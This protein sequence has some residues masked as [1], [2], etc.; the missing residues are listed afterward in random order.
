MDSII[1]SRIKELCAEND[2]TLNKLETEVGM[3]AYSISKGYGPF[4]HTIVPSTVAHPLQYVAFP[5]YTLYQH[6]TILHRS[7]SVAF[8]HQAATPDAHGQ[9]LHDALLFGHGK[10][11]LNPIPLTPLGSACYP[12][13]PY[14]L[15]HENLFCELSLCLPIQFAFLALTGW[16]TQD[17]PVCTVALLI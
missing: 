6:Y 9:L 13:T 2:M 7:S 10:G 3:S 12:P 5:I 8:V 16:D 17:V 1:F 14:P 15:R 11:D 4:S